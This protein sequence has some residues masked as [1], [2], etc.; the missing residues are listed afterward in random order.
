MNVE[1]KIRPCDKASDRRGLERL[2][3]P[4]KYIRQYT[5]SSPLFFTLKLLGLCSNHLYVMTP[6]D[7]PEIIGTILLR[8]RLQGFCPK[9]VWIIHAVGVVEQLRGKGLGMALMKYAL[10]QLREL[11]AQE[12]S[13]KVDA[14]N[15]PAIGLYR[16][17]G[18]TEQARLN[19]QIIFLKRV[20][21]AA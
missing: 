2:E 7:G 17:L 19:G 21:Q 5:N 12:V 8:K 1:F 4:E 18:F 15:D 20:N 10:E 14:D 11:G 9:T 13:L 3:L 6:P 16:K